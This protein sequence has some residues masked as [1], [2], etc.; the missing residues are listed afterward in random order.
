[1][2]LHS[3]QGPERYLSSDASHWRRS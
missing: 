1:L 3:M 2:K